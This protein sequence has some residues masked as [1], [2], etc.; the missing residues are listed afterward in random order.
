[1]KDKVL[2]VGGYGQVG[3]YVTLEL[4]CAFPQKI[5]VA[6]RSAEKANAFAMEN[7]ID[8]EAIE[9]NIYDTD[10]ICNIIKNVKVAVMCL[11]PKNNDFAIFCVKNGIDYIDIS[12]SNDVAKGIEQIKEAA[13][14]NKSTCVLGV[15]LAPGLSNLLVKKLSRNFDVMQRADISLMLGLGEPHGED[16]VKWLLDNLRDNFIVNI[17]GINR[18]IKPFVIKR[19]T[20]F[21]KP[22]GDR[23][24]YRFNLADQYI[25][26]KTLQ[27]ENTAS[28]FC[29]DSK[30][31][32]FYVSMLKRIGIFSL[33]RFKFA[34]N[35][36][37]KLFISML[38]VIRKL[39]LGTDI[40]SI[41]VDVVGVKNGRECLSH[42]GIKG[43]N[44]SFITGKIAAFAAR[45]LLVDN[46][47]SGV[48]Y[49]EELFSLEE[50][51]DI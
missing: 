28:Y 22:L 44:N 11:S 33:L 21:I 41:Q 50:F 3:K 2:I 27:I 24:A 17:D 35:I 23:S 45:K 43:N 36:I 19:K 9:L 1:M 18:S 30:Q 32:T 29:Y 39:K 6:G 49:L 42:I 51:D 40:Y 15:G 46:Y 37:L 13:I 34:Y 10:S 38:P 31:I 4:A 8:I 48:F 25:L 26:Q 5:I 12:P 7:N 20:S 14:S 47:P 16:G